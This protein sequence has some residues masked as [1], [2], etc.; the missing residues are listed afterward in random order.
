MTHRARVAT[1]ACPEALIDTDNWPV[2]DRASWREYL[3]VQPTLGAPGQKRGHA[4][5]H[6]VRR[7]ILEA[8]PAAVEMF[9]CT[10]EQLMS[11]DL[12][13]FFHLMPTDGGDIITFD[14]QPFGGSRASGWRGR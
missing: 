3:R 4:V 14:Q 10:P 8:N 13:Q 1:A 2:T 5:R 7:V 6:H 9:E 11:R 12:T